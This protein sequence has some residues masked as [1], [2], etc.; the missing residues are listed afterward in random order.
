MCES[1]N[2]LR[3]DLLCEGV[4][5]ERFHATEDKQHVRDRVMQILAP[6]T[7]YS[8]DSIIR[9]AQTHPSL[10]KPAE[11]YPRIVFF[12]LLQ[13]VLHRYQNAGVEK[14]VLF[15]DR[16]DF[17][18]QRE[19]I[20]KGVKY[21]LE[22]IFAVKNWRVPYSLLHHESKSHYCLQAVDYCGWAIYVKWSRGRP[23]TMICFARRL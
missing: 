14:L 3:H 10:H 17:K 1:L 4:E 6:C 11:F 5:L 9:T 8:I 22:N 18:S 16:V 13:Y 12:Y 7:D 2:A 19:N 21:N 23:A 15:V 20:E